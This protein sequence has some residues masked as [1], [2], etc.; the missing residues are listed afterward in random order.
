M[1]GENDNQGIV[2]HTV[3]I[4][5]FAPAGHPLR[6]IRK[7]VNTE[8]IRELCAPRYCANNGRLSLPTEQLFLAMPGG[9]LANV[10]A[11]RELIME[12]RRSVAFWRFLG[13]EIGEKIVFVAKPDFDWFFCAAS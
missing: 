5:D 3:Q 2:F 4:E 7:L 12:L 6:R 9:C 11:D 1:M 8:S 13:L 10:G